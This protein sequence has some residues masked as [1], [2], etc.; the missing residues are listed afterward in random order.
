MFEIFWIG[1]F[2]AIVV[3]I[4]AIV[5]ALLF[6]TYLCLFGL[7]LFHIFSDNMSIEGSCWLK[8]CLHIASYKIK[9]FV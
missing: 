5:F 8:Q 3:N 6:I 2:Y 9:R 4:I 7:A 1:C